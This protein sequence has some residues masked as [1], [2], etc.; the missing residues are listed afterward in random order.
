MKGI[1]QMGMSR[2]DSARRQPATLFG[3][4]TCTP[5]VKI[6]DRARPCTPAQ[7]LCEIPRPMTC[8]VAADV[9]SFLR[10]LALNWK[11]TVIRFGDVVAGRH[12]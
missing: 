1:V 10:G 4:C 2:F 5:G 9:S 8:L 7:I 11:R 3:R 6:A 12:A